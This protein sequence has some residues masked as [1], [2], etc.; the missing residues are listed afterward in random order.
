[1]A[2]ALTTTM[3][4]LVYKTVPDAIVSWGD[5]VI[6]AMVTALFCAKVLAT[7]ARRVPALT[8]VAPK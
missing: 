2:M 1:M 5:A 3:F 4:T 6:G 7:P 8:V